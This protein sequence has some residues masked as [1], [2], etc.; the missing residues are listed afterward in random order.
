MQDTT[1][2]CSDKQEKYSVIY[3]LLILPIFSYESWILEISFLRVVS[4]VHSFVYQHFYSASL[5]NSHK[6]SAAVYGSTTMCSLKDTLTFQLKSMKIV[7]SVKE[8]S[9]HVCF[10]WSCDFLLK[11]ILTK[12][13][14]LGHKFFISFGHRRSV[15]TDSNH[16]CPWFAR[17]LLLFLKIFEKNTGQYFHC[18][19]ISVQLNVCAL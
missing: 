13:L 4:C 3:S 7:S 9:H 19:Q 5:K 2:V 14:Y 18:R 6:I 12:T 17:F 15:E 1:N 16:S 8:L 11:N 10:S